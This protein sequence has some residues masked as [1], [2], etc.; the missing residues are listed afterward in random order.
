MERTL[1]SAISPR[2][3]LATHGYAPETIAVNVTW[4]KRIQCLSNALQHVP[5]YLQLFPSNSTRKLKSSPF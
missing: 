5:I 3:T 1:V 4:M 2:H